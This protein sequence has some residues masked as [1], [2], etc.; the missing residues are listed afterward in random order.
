MPI[1]DSV[2][3]TVSQ[4]K[5]QTMSQSKLQLNSKQRHKQNVFTM[6]NKLKLQNKVTSGYI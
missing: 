5:L 1:N 4:S 2:H 3:Q 6:Y